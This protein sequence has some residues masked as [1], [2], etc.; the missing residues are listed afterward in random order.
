M[1]HHLNIHYFDSITTE[2]QAYM[3]GYFYAR[4]TGRLQLPINTLSLLYFFR[5]ELQYDGPIHTYNRNAVMNA[6]GAEFLERLKSL[7]CKTNR[8]I[9]SQLPNLPPNLMRHF[10]RSL[11]D[12]YGRAYYIKQKYVNISLTLNDTLTTDVRTFLRDN[13]AVATHHLFR[14]SHLN[15]T[16]M[17]ITAH[18]SSLHFLYYIFSN[19]NQNCCQARKY[20]KYRQFIEKGVYE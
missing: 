19:I 14:Y 2:A 13:L 8:F 18:S 5:A 7:G 16:E 12:N 1:T 4:G 20:Q 6:G 3:L 17:L 9:N 15:S 11:F 10:L